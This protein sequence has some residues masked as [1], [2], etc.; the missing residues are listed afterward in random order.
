M[1]DS[2]EGLQN[3]IVALRKTTLKKKNLIK[4]YQESIKVHVTRLSLSEQ[5][6]VVTHNSFSD[7]KHKITSTTK[8][9][10]QFLSRNRQLERKKERLSTELIKQQSQ[11]ESLESQITLVQENYAEPQMDSIANELRSIN[12]QFSISMINQNTNHTELKEN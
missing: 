8:V 6:L 10:D 4:K 9:S 2:V 12:D 3:M 7:L 1:S 5:G 11:L